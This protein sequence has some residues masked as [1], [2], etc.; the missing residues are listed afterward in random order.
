MIIKCFKIY[1]GYFCGFWLPGILFFLIQELPYVVMPFLS[2]STNPL[3]KMK[4]A[5]PLLEV[6]EKL[7]GVL[8]ILLLILPVH[9][10]SAGLT[11]ETLRYKIFFFLALFFL[12]LYF[13]GW[14]F[15]FSGY[16]SIK[17]MLTCLVAMPPLYY[18]SLGLW[19]KNHLLVINTAFFLIFHIANVWTSLLLLN[20]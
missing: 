7:F 12:V 6:S 16:Q 8:T 15:Y 19:Q 2:L 13:A 17:L 4:T 9:G 20:C 3:M 18:M 14:Y 1:K 11:S 10:K 5:F